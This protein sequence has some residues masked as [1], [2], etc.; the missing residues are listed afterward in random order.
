VLLRP[1]LIKSVQTIT[2]KTVYKIS[3]SADSTG[4]AFKFCYLIILL[5][6]KSAT[7]TGGSVTFHISAIFKD[8]VQISTD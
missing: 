6:A 1:G 5:M 2:S 7:K 4:A 3:T 8:L